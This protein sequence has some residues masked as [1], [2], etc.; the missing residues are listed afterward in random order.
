MSIFQLVLPC[1]LW[2][3]SKNTG[4]LSYTTSSF[5]HHY[6]PETLTSKENWWFL[7]SVTLK[8]DGWPCKTL[9]HLFSFM[10]SVAH[11]FKAM[12]EFKLE[13][14][15]R[16]AQ[17]GSKSDIFCTEWPCN[18]ADDLKKIG[19]IFYT[20]WSFAHHSV[21]ID[22]FKLEVQSRRAR[23]G[24]NRRYLSHVT[25][26]FDGWPWK[27]IGHLSQVTSS[28]VHHFMMICEFQLVLWFGNG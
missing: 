9:G 2:M 20:M 19:H 5:V 15:S 6:S 1:S 17:F 27:I 4:H 14:Q 8:F 10:S 21:A 26:A 18:L 7:S 24:H 12:G 23:F 11:R 16:S 25:L 28:F 3:T 22:K 13:M